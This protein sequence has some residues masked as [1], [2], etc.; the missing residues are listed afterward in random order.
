[1]NICPGDYITGTDF[2]VF[3]TLDK[4]T[5]LEP[6]ILDE[7]KNLIAWM[8]KIKALP[9][10]NKYFNEPTTRAWPLNNKMASFK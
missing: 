10:L 8:D 2:M 5:V 3:E 6:T 1:M 4:Y 9:T 7:N